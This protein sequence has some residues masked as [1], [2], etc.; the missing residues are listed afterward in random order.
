M[1]DLPLQRDEDL[2]RGA[3]PAEPDDQLIGLLR[4]LRHQGLGEPLNPL[5]IVGTVDDHQWPATN[6][7]DAPGLD[8]RGDCRAQRILIEGVIEEHLRGRDRRSQIGDL[9]DAVQWQVQIRVWGVNTFD[10]CYPASDRDGFCCD[11]EVV[12]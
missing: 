9:V 1:S 5:L 2:G 4:K 6:H 8:G 3:R 7:L 10:I 11:K 12:R